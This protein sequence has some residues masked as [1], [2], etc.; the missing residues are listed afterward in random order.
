MEVAA[1]PTPYPVILSTIP[2]VILPDFASTAKATN[3]VAELQL[4]ITAVSK[5]QGAFISGKPASFLNL[6]SL[7]RLSPIT[8]K[9]GW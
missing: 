4:L 7:L 8:P 9:L 1:D 2:G 5:T 3:G 6:S